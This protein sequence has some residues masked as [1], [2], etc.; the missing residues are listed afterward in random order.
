MPARPRATAAA[1]PHGNRVLSRQQGSHGPRVGE[2]RRRVHRSAS[3]STVGKTTRPPRTAR[4]V[5]TRQRA[6]RR[7]HAATRCTGTHAATRHDAT[8]PRCDA[9]MAGAPMC[10]RCDAITA[11]RCA[12]A[13]PQFDA[14]IRNATPT[15]S[16]ANAPARATSCSA[17]R[18]ARAATR[19][20]CAATRW[21]IVGALL[22]MHAA[23]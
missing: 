4:A 23:R 22:R 17:M 20:A 18:R 12:H 21:C 14:P 11:H 19:H 10:S 9:I 5:N 1:S 6:L 15:R 8:R 2:G 13:P 3:M 16:D 7:A